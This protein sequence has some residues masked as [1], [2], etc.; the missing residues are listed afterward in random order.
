M[1]KTRS[2][3]NETKRGVYEPSIWSGVDEGSELG[4]VAI[5]CSLYNLPDR[6]IRALHYHDTIELGLCLGGNGECHTADG[7]TPVGE[8]SVELF[9]PYER[10]YSR[11]LSKEQCVWRFIQIDYYRLCGEN[12]MNDFGI[13][14]MIENAVGISGII[15]E[16]KYPE[17]AGLIRRIVDEAIN[18]RYGRYRII[19]SL[20]TELLVL[21]ARASEG[22]PKIG[23]TLNPNMS[24]LRPALV[25][26][27]NNYMNEISVGTLASL[28]CMSVS[29]MRVY[30]KELTGDTP[31]A[32][33]TMIRVNCA[34]ELIVT[35]KLSL[36]EIAM[37]TGFGDASSFYRAF[38]SLTGVSPSEYR[39]GMMK[40]GKL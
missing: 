37:S 40:Y 24:R 6:E 27:R 8:G 12:G 15:D 1:Q 11:S 16:R 26:I 35:T 30:F 13:T 36:L 2:G 5:G 32:Y 20:L 3:A 19:M 18:R 29:Q 33:I 23:Q 21:N 25:Y 28:C 39:S 4:E 17:L 34:K 31:K 7:I 22:L 38:R 10:H 14:G 9:F